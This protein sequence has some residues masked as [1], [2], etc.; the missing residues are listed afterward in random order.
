MVSGATNTKG[1]MQVRWF[2][3]LRKQKDECMTVKV[4]HCNMSLRVPDS[5]KH[6]K[7]IDQKPSTAPFN[8][9]SINIYE[10]L[11]CTSQCYREMVETFSYSF[12]KV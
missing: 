2:G 3:T 12:I 5:S 11:L 1:K 4:D 10:Y 9:I 6:G 7:C 8:V